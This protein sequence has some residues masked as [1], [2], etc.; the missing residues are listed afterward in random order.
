MRI[1]RETGRWPLRTVTDAWVYMLAAGENIADDSDALGK[2]SVEKF[3]LLTE[4]LIEALKGADDTHGMNLA[5]ES[6][7]AHDE[8][9]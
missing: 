5:I 9:E 6:A 4:P 3:A 8:E 1:A 7:F 2:M